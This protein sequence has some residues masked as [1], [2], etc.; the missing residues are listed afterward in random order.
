MSS[1]ITPINSQPSFGTKLPTQNV[2]EV[3]TARYLGE[4]GL[5][6]FYKVC[7]TMTGK[8]SINR[9]I[10][11]VGQQCSAA[12]KKQFPVL[13]DAAT[14]AKLFFA[15]GKKDLNQI[16]RWVTK[17]VKEIGIELDVKPIKAD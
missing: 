2:L 17:W 6:G 4:G 10:S 14:D 1:T 12:L 13:E 5:D 8:N 3:V 16:N 15:N 9:E 11:E 7:D